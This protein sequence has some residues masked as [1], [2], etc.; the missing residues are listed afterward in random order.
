[1][2]Q[3]IDRRSSQQPNVII[4]EKEDYDDPYFMQKV[5]A[6]APGIHEAKL[7]EKKEAEKAL[8]IPRPIKQK[9]RKAYR[10]RNRSKINEILA[11]ATI[12]GISKDAIK[13]DFEQW[14]SEREFSHAKK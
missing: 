4:V 1:M 10:S 9:L 6:V 7:K 2:V 11:E 12:N 8:I 5:K 14:Q 13:A 3:I